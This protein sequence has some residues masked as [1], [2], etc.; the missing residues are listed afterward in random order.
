[1]K[2]QIYLSFSEREYFRPKVKDTNKR[3]QYK[4]KNVLQKKVTLPV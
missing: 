2:N 1:M 3:E 4:T